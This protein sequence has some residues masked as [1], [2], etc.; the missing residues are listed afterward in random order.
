MHFLW[1]LI[2]EEHQTKSTKNDHHHCKNWELYRHILEKLV[3]CVNEK[4]VCLQPVHHIPMLKHKIHT[5]QA[6]VLLPRKDHRVDHQTL[7]YTEI[8]HKKNLNC[9]IVH[10]P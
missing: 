7:H 1:S 8:A 4:D 2:N 10:A 5:I 6:T 9:Y 3:G